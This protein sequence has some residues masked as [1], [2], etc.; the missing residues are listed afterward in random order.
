MKKSENFKS[1][2]PHPTLLTGDEVAKI[3]KVSKS[4]AYL[5]MKKGEIPVVRIGR[6]VRVNLE[7]LN[8]FIEN[9]TF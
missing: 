3:L 6:S 8:T 7:A 9:K 2:T 4:F 1:R 5:L